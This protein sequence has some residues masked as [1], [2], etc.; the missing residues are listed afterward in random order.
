M[1]GT[2]FQFKGVIFI[3]DKKRKKRRLPYYIVT[4]W[5]ILLIAFYIVA[6]PEFSVRELLNLR[7]EKPIAAAALFLLLYALKSA[8]VVFP[9]MVLEIAVGHIFSHRAALAVNFL[10]ILIIL[11]VPY[12]IGRF[13]GID[14]IQR[15]VKKYPKFEAILGKQQENSFFLCF[16]LRIVGCLP[17]DVVTMYLGATRTPFYKNL[18]GGALGMLPSMILATLIGE[19]IQNP[20]SPMFWVS[21]GLKIFLVGFSMLLYYLYRQK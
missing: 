7:P 13:V 8:F 6:E 11:T 15:L 9:L 3:K 5:G 17:G 21:V 18:A 14:A 4:V 10:G 16:F 19:S 1:N 20:Q 2:G 12:R